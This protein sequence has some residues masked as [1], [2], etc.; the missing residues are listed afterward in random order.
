MHLSYH[1][2][3]R[4][5]YLQ[6]PGPEQRT[7]ISQ[8]MSLKGFP[9]CVGFIDGTTFPIYPRPGIDG[10]TFFE[11]KNR[12]SIN[13]QIV[14]DCDRRITAL[15]TG[16]PGSCHDNKCYQIMSLAQTPEECFG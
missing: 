11:Q 5:H 13:A 15:Y 16:W 12:Y 6:C 10:E 3:L 2:H 1:M 7:E 4:V 9:G 8:V 14:R